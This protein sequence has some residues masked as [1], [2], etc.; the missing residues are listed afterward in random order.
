M[1]RTL[2]EHIMINILSYHIGLCVVP[3]SVALSILRVERQVGTSRSLLL[4]APT[5]SRNPAAALVSNGTTQRMH[6]LTHHI[7]QSAFQDHHH[8]HSKGT[9]GK[10]RERQGLD[11]GVLLHFIPEVRIPRI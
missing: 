2:F 3:H 5:D 6:P 4:S 1:V 10:G 8:R 7:S 9:M 11:D